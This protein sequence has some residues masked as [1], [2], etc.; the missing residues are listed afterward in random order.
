MRLSI[1]DLTIWLAFWHCAHSMRSRVYKTVRCLSVRLSHQSNAATACGGFAAER[2]TGK[3]IDRQRRAPGSSSAAARGRSTALSS[4]CGQC[5]VDSRVD[6]TEHRL[7]LISILLQF[8]QYSLLVWNLCQGGNMHGIIYRHIGWTGLGWIDGQNLPY[9]VV[10]NLA[11]LTTLLHP[12]N[13][14]FSRTT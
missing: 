2:R 6:E 14:L 12:F 11:T 8:Q 1:G 7:G 4:K 9:F 10:E 3:D 5:H 13:G